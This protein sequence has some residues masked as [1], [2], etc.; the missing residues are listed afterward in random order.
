MLDQPTDQPTIPGADDDDPEVLYAPLTAALTA[1]AFD[2]VPGWDMVGEYIAVP[3][4]DAQVW[5]PRWNAGGLDIWVLCR[6]GD[7]VDGAF[8]IFGEADIPADVADLT[9]YAEITVANGEEAIPLV[10]LVLRKLAGRSDQSLA[11]LVE[12]LA[13]E[14]TVTAAYAADAAAEA[15]APA[16]AVLERVD[17]PTPEWW[18]CAC[19][20][21]PDNAGFWPCDATGTEVAEDEIPAWAGHL[22]VCVVCGRIIDGSTRDDSTGRVAVVGRRVGSPSDL[23]GRPYPSVSAYALTVLAMAYEPLTDPT[24]RAVL[25]CAA[26]HADA[27][28]N[29]SSTFAFPD[30]DGYAGTAPAYLSAWTGLDRDTVDGAVFGLAEAGWLDQRPE[31]FGL[32]A[33]ARIPQSVFDHMTR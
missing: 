28:S 25:L 7:N 17:A 26:A 8:D 21:E 18:T 33:R 31:E 10:V 9:E 19:G 24:H 13:N 12:G 20:N 2:W 30:R 27:A 32:P 1:T 16:P 29:P 15:T 4:A 3:Q 23:T 11:E 6:A 5:H 14:A 22:Y